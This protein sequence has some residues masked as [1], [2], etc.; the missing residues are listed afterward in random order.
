MQKRHFFIPH[1]IVIAALSAL[2]SLGIFLYSLIAE[3]PEAVRAATYGDVSTFVGKLYDGDGGQALDAYFDFPEDLDV[4]ASGNFY[5][6]DTYNNVVRKIDST[7]IVSTVSGTGSTGD[8]DG[9][10]LSAQFYQP[11]GI[12]ID[13]SGNIFISDTG[14]NKVKKISGGV[15]TT[16]V[17]SDLNTPLG[18]EVI[19]STLYIADSGNNMI[20]KVSVDGGIVTL[21]AGTGL[22]DPRRMAAS[23]DGS[24]LYVADNGSHRV[25]SVDAVTGAVSVIAGS[26]SN[27]YTEGTGESASFE[28]VWGVAFSGNHLYVSD[29]NFALI[30]RVRKINLSTKAT[31]LV[32]QDTRQAEMI[33]PAG[34]VVKDDFVYVANSGLGTIH[35]FNKDDGT[36]N[37][38]FAGKDRFGNEV[39]TVDKALVGRPNDLAITS[40]RSTIFVSVNNLVRK[41]NRSTGEVTHVLGSVVDNYR[42]EGTDAQFVRFSGITSIAVNSD[43][44]KLYVIDRWNNRIRGIDLTANPIKSFLVTGAGLIN[45][46]GSQDNGYQEGNNCGDVRTTGQAACSYFRNPMGLVLDP[47]ENFL[48]VTDTGNNRI[49]KVRIYDGQTYAVAGTG[50]AGFADGT[51]SSAKFNKPSTLA[52]DS[53]G[54]TLYVADTSNQRIRKIDLTTNTVSTLIGSGLAGYRD[55]IGTSAVVSYPEYIKMGGDNLLYF[56]DSGSHRIRQV[57]PKT[58][59][60]KLVAGSGTRGLLNGAQGTAQFNNLNGLAVDSAGNALYVA[61]S[62]NDLVRKVDIT[63]IAAYTDP[64]PEVHVVSPQEIN[65][66]WDKG[67]GLQVKMEGKNFRYG[68]KTYFA[69]ILSP[70]TIV[71]SSSSIAVQVPTKLM[72]PGWYDIT[73][74]NLDGQKT[75]LERGLGITNFITQTPATFF[76]Y[77]KKTASSV[78]KGP[79]I[80]TGNSFFAFNEKVRGGYFVGMGNVLGDSAKEIIVGSGN[81]Q[82]SEVRVFDANRKLKAKFSPFGSKAKSGARVAVCDITGDKIDDIIVAPGPKYKPEIRLFKGNGKS[83]RKPFLALDKKFTGG[84]YVACGDTNGDGKNEIVV[85]AGQKGSGQAWV[86]NASGKLTA[87]F[88]VFSSKTF[89]DG[90]RVVVADIDGDKKGEIIIGTETGTPLIHVFKLASK[91]LKVRSIAPFSKVLS[92]G[93]SIT[94]ADIDGDGKKEII[95]GAGDKSAPT[96]KAYSNKGVVKK[97]FYAYAARFR[98]GVNAAGGDMDGDGLDDFVVAP[99]GSA[100]PNIRIIR[101]I[102]LK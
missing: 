20:K 4:D 45:T 29:H 71:Q 87:K 76:E 61:D 72:K 94:A 17:A 30:D 24:L 22:S 89:A 53:T 92:K 16:L 33:F 80:A 50:E 90:M 48:Y 42:G 1:V 64:G 88:T 32:Y 8:A 6:P 93:V 36:V 41:I 84:L 47:G 55:A 23:N 63:G 73:V 99:Q 28:N 75:T 56:S 86:Y 83:A 14:N 19:G 58:G 44:T 43:G 62:W 66:I 60:T 79:E 13:A 7:G 40:D 37:S 85:T 52:I 11:R 78:S 77:S 57:D 18:L 97:E 9:A 70:K 95:A 2:T 82:L 31:T 25:L 81:D 5:L 65:P 27:T 39:G 51:A 12:A 100:G 35:K 46:N 21:V 96:V 54:K 69:D 3:R 98:G 67:T 38:K 68:A 34:L 59:L 15:V 91:A 10:V 49:R 101:T 102:T 74:I 26:G